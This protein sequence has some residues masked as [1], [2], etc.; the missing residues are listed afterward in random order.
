MSG[1]L[2]IKLMYCFPFDINTI[3]F[4]VQQFTIEQ[5]VQLELKQCRTRVQQ[6]NF[7]AGQ[8]KPRSTVE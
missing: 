3:V 5:L 6:T 8:R 4:D 1:S 2:V 7:R